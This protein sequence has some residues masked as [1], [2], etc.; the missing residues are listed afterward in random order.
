MNNCPHVYFI[1]YED[2]FIGCGEIAETKLSMHIYRLKAIS[3]SQILLQYIEFCVKKYNTFF[4]K[5]QYKVGAA[6]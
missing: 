3:A 6:Q 1:F 5:Y 2:P 4:T